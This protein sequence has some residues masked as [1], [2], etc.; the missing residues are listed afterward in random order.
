MPLEIETR[1][2]V[3]LLRLRVSPGARKAA[4]KGEH[5]GALKLSVTE[6]PEKGK[7]NEGVVAL[8]ADALGIPQRNIEIIAGH[9]SQDKR[10]RIAG[11]TEPELRSRLAP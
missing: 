6:P 7:A 11:I 10:V 5:G 3:C 2:G 8:L 1:D 9:T 4:I